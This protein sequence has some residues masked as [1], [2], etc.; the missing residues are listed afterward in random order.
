MTNNSLITSTF[1]AQFGECLHDIIV[2]YPE[3]SKLKTYTRYV[4]SVK[5]VNPSLLIKTWKSYITDKYETTIEEGNLEYFLN[6]DYKEDI[7]SLEKSKTI[8]EIIDYLRSIMLT[9]SPENKTMSFQ[10]IQNL[11]RLSKHYV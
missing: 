1:N 3:E 2:L 11:T 6:K 5:K 9:M 4:E 8:E 7:V 10:Y